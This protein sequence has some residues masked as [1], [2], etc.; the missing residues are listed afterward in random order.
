[1]ALRDKLRD[2]YGPLGALDGTLYLAD[3]LMARMSGG[4]LR[5][6]KYLLV[7]QPV[8][9]D[10][11]RP[12]RDDPATRILP[13]TAADTGLRSEFPRP[14]AV[15]DQR[16]AQGASCLCAFVKE[17]FA[18][19]LW[20]VRERYVEDEVRCLFVF[21]RPE[22][23]AWDFDVY[24]VPEYRLGR[25]LARLWSAANRRLAADGVRWS[26]S[27]ISAFNKASLAA[28][29]RL[30]LRHCRSVIYLRLGPVQLT[31]WG[32]APFVHLSFSDAQRPV[33]RLAPPGP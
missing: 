4:H 21:D 16:Y 3:Q 12:L 28:H 7:A 26:F 14:P 1:M 33:V 30:G 17:R 15:I 11:G 8:P 5:L 31:L 22:H 25:T 19:Y 6:F 23:S 13:A 9:V 20:W 18:G 32:A 10:G 2:V 27:R 29:A 24:V